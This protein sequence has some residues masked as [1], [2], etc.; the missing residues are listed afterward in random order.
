MPKHT[1]FSLK[2]IPPKFDP[3][4]QFRLDQL[5]DYRGEQS[6]QKVTEALAILFGAIEIQ[7]T[8]KYSLA[9]R[10]GVD[11]MITIFSSR[12]QEDRFNRRKLKRTQ[13]KLPLQIKSS[14]AGAKKFA[15]DKQNKIPVL[16]RL[17]GAT[18]EQ[19]ITAFRTIVNLY[20]PFKKSHKRGIVVIAGASGK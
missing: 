7:K 14:P 18:N 4:L 2:H 16:V 11:L 1:S 9:D 12:R 3:D 13:A 20:E 10:G 17:P 5:N 15:G 6:V 19:I 8:E